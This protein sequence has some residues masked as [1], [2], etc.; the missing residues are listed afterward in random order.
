MKVKMILAVL[1]SFCLL[2]GAGSSLNVKAASGDFVSISYDSYNAKI[3]FA[4]GDNVYPTGWFSA[5]GIAG[6]NYSYS[7][8]AAD[9]VHSMFY[10]FTPT[11]GGTFLSS[12]TYRFN[13]DVTYYGSAIDDNFIEVYSFGAKDFS[14]L[15]DNY[16]LSFSNIFSRSSVSVSPY[17][18]KRTSFQVDVTP[19]NSI[20]GCIILEL[21]FNQVNLVNSSSHSVGLDVQAAGDSFGPVGGIL[22]YHSVDCN[23]FSPKL[24]LVDGTGNTIWQNFQSQD[25]NTYRCHVNAF[26]DIHKVYLLVQFDPKNFVTDNKFLMHAKFDSPYFLFNDDLSTSE[27]WCASD[28]N[29]LADTRTDL[30]D[31]VHRFSF[32]T[33]FPAIEITEA[34]FEFS[35][36][37]ADS[38]LYILQ[39]N[40]TDKQNILEDTN[41]YI[42]FSALDIT[43][44]GDPPF[45]EEPTTQPSEQ[46]TE[47]PTTRDPVQDA[48]DQG[49]Q[50]AHEDAQQAHQDAEEQKGLL[51]KIVD[52]ILG[53]PK[54]LIDGLIDGLKNLF[55]PDSDKVN[56]IITDIQNSFSDSFGFLSYPFDLLGKVLN[57]F[58]KAGGDAVI[59]VPEWRFMDHVVIPEYTYNL[60]ENQIVKQ[61]LP[62]IRSLTSCILA[63]NFLGLCRKKYDEVIKGGGS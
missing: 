20:S 19:A 37:N 54:K 56:E 35:P 36:V 6:D 59:T 42:S 13:I 63:W 40:L 60:S 25:Q 50:Q 57:L 44:V 16:D 43:E 45:S 31:S 52:G 55:I 47:E 18:S 22:D 7:L 21:K 24:G 41:M 9:G 8:S 46:P 28:F 33:V 32:G 2:F 53:L 39:L 58:L 49:N 4:C 10:V 30:P 3:G 62:Y 61:L 23:R 14:N 15:W 5:S 26:S 1:L 29:H 12:N 11:S 38:Q 17:P 48:I 27:G 51:G 34:E